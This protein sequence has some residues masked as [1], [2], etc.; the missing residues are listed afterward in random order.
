MPTAE[1]PA[2]IAIAPGA[3]S[4]IITVSIPKGTHPRLFARLKVVQ[5]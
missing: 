4:D 3:T 1:F 2:T 5:P